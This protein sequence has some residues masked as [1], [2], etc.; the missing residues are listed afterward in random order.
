SKPDSVVVTGG[1]P[2]TYNLDIFCRELKQR[3][4]KTFLETSGA[5]PL[6]G[7]WDWICLS[8]KKNSPPVHGILA[9]ADELKQIIQTPEDF[10]WAEENAS[11]VK[12]DC[13]LF[14]QP[15]W[16]R[17]EHIIQDIVEYVKENTRWSVSLQAHKFMHIP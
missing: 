11:K 9:K 10:A 3:G 7:E 6:S 16:S 8:P 5:Y 12:Q 2:L 15:E 17:Y 1:E 4:L 13:K 14:L